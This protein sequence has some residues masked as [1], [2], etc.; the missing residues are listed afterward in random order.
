MTYYNCAMFHCL[1]VFTEG[2][3]QN[4]QLGS[5]VSENTLGLL[6]LIVKGLGGVT[7]MRFLAD[8]F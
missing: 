2:E 5:D 6:G 8:N 3:I 7:P 4:P 1:S